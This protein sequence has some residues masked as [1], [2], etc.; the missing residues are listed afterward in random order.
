ME[1]VKPS[2]KPG[3]ESEPVSTP[4]FPVSFELSTIFY[5][6]KIEQTNHKQLPL[7]TIKTEYKDPLV[8]KLT[9]IITY[10]ETQTKNFIFETAAFFN[11]SLIELDDLPEYTTLLQALIKNI[12]TYFKSNK[13]PKSTIR[14]NF[15]A[16][17][18][19]VACK[20]TTPMFDHNRVCLKIKICDTNYTLKAQILHIYPDLQVGGNLDRRP[21]PPVGVPMFSDGDSTQASL[22]E[23]K[24]TEPYNPPNRGTYKLHLKEGDLEFVD[25]ETLVFKV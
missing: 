20:K 18:K 21:R 16:L 9:D 25:M 1:S 3:R 8:Q 15:K 6:M 4:S 19:T 13:T 5:K 7:F 17:Y 10:Y 24:S 23:T 12:D 11:A 2:V 14:I 22:A